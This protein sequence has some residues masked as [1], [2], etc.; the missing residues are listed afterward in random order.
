MR[1][2]R[3]SLPFALAAASAC[4]G[5]AAGPAPRTLWQA[6]GPPLRL[7]PGVDWE[8]VTPLPSPETRSRAGGAVYLRER[9]S[10]AEVGGVVDAFMDAWTRKS[11][12]DLVALLGTDAGPIEARGRGRAALVDDWRDRLRSYDYGR[13]AGVELVRRER[14]QMHEAGDEDAADRVLQGI[15]L[16]PQEIYVR[17]PLELNALGGEKLFGDVLVFILRREEGELRIVGYGE[18]SS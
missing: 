11:I 4:G 14:V 18:T 2:S 13:L 1:F 9:V 12:D 5:V 15:D 6:D 7:T 3:A 17:V 10:K 8:P 16:R